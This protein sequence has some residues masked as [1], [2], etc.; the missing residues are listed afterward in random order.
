MAAIADYTLDT[1]AKAYVEAA[2]KGK[3]VTVETGDVK[4][5]TSF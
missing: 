3:P 5:A 2:G 1:A 4:D